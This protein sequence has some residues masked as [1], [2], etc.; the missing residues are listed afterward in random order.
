V[1]ARAP[2]RGAA[3]ASTDRRRRRR[4]S[5]QRLERLHQLVA[6]GFELVEPLADLLLHT[7]N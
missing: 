6:L 2:P 1:T 5:R 4:R 3:P 7:I